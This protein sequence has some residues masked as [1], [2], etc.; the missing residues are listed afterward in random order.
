M[1]DPRTLAADLE[2]EA[3]EWGGEDPIVPKLH[4]ACHLL[5]DVLAPLHDVWLQAKPSC[6]TCGGS[7]R[8]EWK[9]VAHGFTRCSECTFGVLPFDKWTAGLV[10]PT[11][12]SDWEGEV[13]NDCHKRYDRTIWWAPD[14]LWLQLVGCSGGTLCPGCFDDRAK[15]IGLFLRWVPQ[16]EPALRQIGGTR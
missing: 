14:E 12:P 3:L 2:E 11:E 10:A 1:S 15:A 5:R 6:P 9:S 16:V 7:M 4:A 8:V 13:C